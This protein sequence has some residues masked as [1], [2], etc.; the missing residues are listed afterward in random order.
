M[1]DQEK[2]AKY[3]A[4]AAEATFDQ[5]ASVPQEMV[6]AAGAIDHDNK[7]W[8]RRI[9][10]LAYS[11]VT[12]LET[13]LVEARKK[14]DQ[15]VAEGQDFSILLSTELGKAMLVDESSYPCESGDYSA[16]WLEALSE[17]QDKYLAAPGD[18]LP[19]HRNEEGK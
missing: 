3:S 14:I 1:F 2:I 9:L 8:L 17:V 15:F 12:A 4:L 6:T 5:L 16:G 18:V 13:E 11:R 19:V 7:P 10:W